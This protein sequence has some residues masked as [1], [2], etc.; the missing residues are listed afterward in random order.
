MGITK[1]RISDDYNEQ[2]EVQA[3]KNQDDTTEKG[4][5]LKVSLDFNPNDYS[6]PNTFMMYTPDQARQLAAH[7]MEAAHRADKGF[8]YYRSQALSGY[9]R[10]RLLD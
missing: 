4:Y 9:G 5:R 6:D 3:S 7:L 8:Y 1:V 2:A 10:R